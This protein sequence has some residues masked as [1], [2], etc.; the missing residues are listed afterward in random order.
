MSTVAQHDVLIEIDQLTTKL[1]KNANNIKYLCRMGSLQLDD[2]KLSRSLPFINRAIEQLQTNKATT[3]QH[4]MDL[5]DVMIKYWMADKYSNAKEMKTN[6]SVDRE[7][8]LIHTQEILAIVMTKKDTEHAHLLALRHAY[9]LECRGDFQASLALLS[10]LIAVQAMDG[11][12]LSFIIFKAAILLKHVGQFKQSIEYLEFILDDPPVQD[13][14][15]KTHVTAF[16]AHAYE[17]CGDKYKVFL[18]KAYKELLQAFAE[19]MPTPYAKLTTAAKASGGGKV[20]QNGSELWEMLA[21][22]AIDRCE[23][24]LAA[25]FL[26]Q[27]VDKS[28]GSKTK[29]CLLLL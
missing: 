29:V 27:A 15:T 10:D 28:A 16:L 13:G 1:A 17:Q 21:L 20:G 6:L 8:F 18:P 25:E 12:D 11:V 14:F 19:D 9:V 2:S 22:Q 24:V 7:N 4:G 23:Y 5:V 3:L 26:S